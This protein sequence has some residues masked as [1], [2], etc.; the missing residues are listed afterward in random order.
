MREESK[1]NRWQRLRTFAGVIAVAF[2][3]TLALVVGN[4]LS[5][6][7]LGVL[8]GAVC[9]VGAAIPTSLLIV[10]V[11]RGR[12]TDNRPGET[13]IA[14]SHQQGT[15]PPVVIINPGQDG[16]YRGYDQLP[17]LEQPRS[18]RCF[19]IVGDGYAD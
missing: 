11:T 13:S 10:A 5:T 1:S 3:V 16:Q 2:A 7:A 12:S 19:T 4:R 8:A 15:Y 9:G 6:E 14:P 18:E 17:D